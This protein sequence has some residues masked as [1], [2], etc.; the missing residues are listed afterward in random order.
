MSRFGVIDL[1]SNAVRLVIYDRLS[2][3]PF[4]LHTEKVFCGL[5]RDMNKTGHLSPEG[6]KLALV[7]LKRFTSLLQAMTVS[8]VEAV[9]TAALRDATDGE[10][11]VK[12]VEDE[13]GLHLKVL[14]GKEE[15]A[16]SALG[17]AAAIPGADGVVADLGGGSLELID[18]SDGV[19]YDGVSL[20]LGM[21]KL[22][23]L[24]VERQNEVLDK[25]L[26]EIKWLQHLKGRSLYLVG[27]SW[28]RLAKLHMAVNNYPLD[29][30]HHY[31]MIPEEFKEFFEELSK[32]KNKYSKLLQKMKRKSENLPLSALVLQKVI[33]AGNPSEIYI[34]SSGLREGCLFKALSLQ[35][36]K[37]DPLIAACDTLMDK[38][39]RIEFSG[40]SFYSW[41]SPLFED[42]KYARLRQAASYLSDM[43]WHEQPEFRASYAFRRV[44]TLSVIGISHAERA[45]LAFALAIRYGGKGLESS[46][47]QVQDLLDEEMQ[48]DALLVGLGLYLAHGIAAGTT[49]LLQQTLLKVEPFDVKLSFTNNRYICDGSV[50]QERLQL[51][52]AAFKD[53]AE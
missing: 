18:I 34:S 33:E 5:G 17:V 8:H 20:P 46:L 29:M 15:A 12:Q 31:K 9:A 30:V 19:T 22:E 16:F 1:G 25:A 42:E 38:E 51:L 28:R 36:K 41:I 50:V 6:V 37:R 43:A 27:G 32:K 4:T 40:Q 53:S 49:K 14:S 35:E 45:Y 47:R 10:A 21:S 24:A 52:R 7:N 48:R 2:L 3:G 44:M 26:S 11:F 39:S 23:P 13:T